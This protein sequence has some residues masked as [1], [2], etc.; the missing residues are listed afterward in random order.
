MHRSPGGCPV[1]SSV[2]AGEGLRAATGP[3]RADPDVCFLPPTPHRGAR[4]QQ[5][6]PLP[7]RMRTNSVA[8]AESPRN[9]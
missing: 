9:L 2:P 4:V 6:G 5:D 1:E 7:H 8:F 3:S